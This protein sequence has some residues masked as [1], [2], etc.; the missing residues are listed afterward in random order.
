MLCA[1]LTVDQTIPMNWIVNDAVFQ[2]DANTW[3]AGPQASLLRGTTSPAAW[4]SVSLKVVY[5]PGQGSL[6]INLDPWYWAIEAV[7][8]RVMLS[9]YIGGNFFE[10]WDVEVPAIGQSTIELTADLT[11]TSLTV[12]GQQLTYKSTVSTP[13]TSLGIYFTEGIIFQEPTLEVQEFQMDCEPAVS[14][15]AAKSLEFTVDFF[16]DV[17]LTPFTP[18]MLDEMFRVMARLNTSKA[19]WIHHGQ[20]GNGFWEGSLGAI[21]ME[22]S[23]ELLGNDYLPPAVQSAHK[24]G[25]PLIGILKPFDT[26]I[27]HT[28]NMDGAVERSA[29]AL[30]G[31]LDMGFDFPAAHP[32]ICMQRRTPFV[33]QKPPREIVIR[34]RGQIAATAADIALFI[35]RD[36]AAYQPYEGPLNIEIVGREITLSGLETHCEFVALSFSPELAAQIQNTLPL[37]AEARDSEGTLLDFTYSIAARMKWVGEYHLSC[38][39]EYRDFRKHGL[40][41]DCAGHGVPNAVWNSGKRQLE[42]YSPSNSH[43]VLGLAFGGNQQIPAALSEAEP[44]A[45]TWWLG[46]IE[47]ML[48]AG[49]DGVEIRMVNHSNII[50][51]SLYGFNVPVVEEYQR[52]Y[53]LDITREDFSREKF[54][55]LRGEFFTAFLRKA[56]EMTR[57]R[58]KKF[59]LHIE[60][61]HQGPA[62]EPCPMEIALPWRQ[63]IEEEICDGVTLKAL[64]VWA[65]DTAFGREVIAACHA[66]GIPVSFASFIHSVFGSSQKEEI[67]QSYLTSPYDA[68]NVYEFATL[69]EFTPDGEAKVADERLVDWLKSYPWSA[70]KALLT[71]N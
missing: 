42:L 16:D 5:N 29:D 41:F 51:W 64:N 10:G 61:V 62:S 14:A 30:G 2:P 56:S 50:D 49:V 15:A 44:A 55:A 3:L 68:F 70:P 22:R 24:A 25:I 36:N 27:M 28:T 21:N 43:N 7:Q 33:T 40:N 71:A 63:W 34:S 38:G 57:A 60:D 37:L 4:E 23:F 31:K 46:E 53:G 54:R 8:G 52:R 26:A 9:K 48:D 13:M 39:Y 59:H 18:E 47:K 11:S 69:F 67:L 12:N 20:R 6:Y 35:S 1:R 66:K 58:G 65:N 45:H 19:Y 17:L 32:E